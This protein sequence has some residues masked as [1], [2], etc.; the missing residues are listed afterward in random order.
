DYYA[1][2]D[3]TAA[4]SL[5]NTNAGTGQFS[6]SLGGV[7]GNIGGVT[8]TRSWSV[9]R[10]A[11]PIVSGVP[12]TTYSVVA[13][14]TGPL[15]AADY[16]PN[17]TYKIVA[18]TVGWTDATGQQQTVRLEDAIAALD[19]SDSARNQRSAGGR[20]RGPQVIIFDPSEEAGVIP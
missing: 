1:L 6:G 3:S 20:S 8:F 13:S 18:V 11:L 4:Q 15:D 9:T 12:S 10:Y 16:V 19:P 17:S 2:T 5:D 14:D 7:S